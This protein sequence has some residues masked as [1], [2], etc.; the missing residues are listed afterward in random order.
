[1]RGVIIVGALM[2][3]SL[4]V[5]HCTKSSR[6][7]TGPRSDGLTGETRG[8]AAV[9]SADCD[10]AVAQASCSAECW[11]SDCCV[12][13]NPTTHEAAC[14]CFLG[15]SSC[16]TENITT[17][18]Q[19]LYTKQ[20][21][22]RITLYDTRIRDFFQFM[23]TKKMDTRGLRSNYEQLITAPE[24]VDRDGRNVKIKVDAA[25]YNVFNKG[26]KIF[27]ES[28]AKDHKAEIEQYIKTVKHQ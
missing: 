10:C 2:V 9:K 16:R 24:A 8:L 20:K 5:N 18:Q 28:L 21:E 11:F 22:H 15:F 7:D 26:Y 12:C 25:K 23:D 14:G 6:P 19:E 27:I 4:L 13:F 3:T 17:K 1:M